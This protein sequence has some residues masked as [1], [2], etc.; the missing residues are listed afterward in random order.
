MEV[1]ELLRLESTRRS[2]PWDLDGLVKS[3]RV[4]PKSYRSIWISDLHF[5]TRRIQAAALLDFLRHNDAENLFLVGDIIDGWK[6]A[7]DWFWNDEQEAAAAELRSWV[8]S[9]RRV[10]LLPGNHDLCPE[11]GER[12]LGLK[13]GPLE[14]IYTTGEGRRML[15][16]HGHQFDRRLAGGK[17][18]QSPTAYS[19]SLKISEWY[20][21]DWTQCVI[22]SGRL[23]SFL[24]YR[25]KRAVEYFMDFDDRAIFSA[26]RS[27]RA[28]GIICG[29]IHR[30]EQRLIGPVW[31]INDGDWV[32]SRTALVEGWD[33]AL[34]LLRWDSQH[35]ESALH[36]FEGGEA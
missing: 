34:C 2:R 1:R 33:G 21:R 20:D 8:R 31:Y 22:Q 7:I 16:T 35:T 13:Y 6:S 19:M 27:H 23:S 9:S 32:D 18:W 3:R 25:V 30:A 24:R 29:H 17:W 14:L 12:L 36:A 5:G 28:D 10:T 26:V 4:E 15:V 11:A